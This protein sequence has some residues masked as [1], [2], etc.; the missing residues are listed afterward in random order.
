M[1]NEPTNAEDNRLIEISV[2]ESF[3]RVKKKQ[4]WIFYGDEEKIF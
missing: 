1:I 3:K 2:N 4:Q